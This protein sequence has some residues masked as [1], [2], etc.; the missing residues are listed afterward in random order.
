MGTSVN[1][2]SPRTLSWRAAQAGYRDPNVSLDRIAAEVWRAASNQPFGNLEQLLSQPII[3]RIG[4]LLGQSAS[5]LEL[6]RQS[7]LTVVQSKHSSLATEIARRACVQA[8]GTKD[9]QRDFT[10]KLI[11]EA[12]G[13]LVSRDLPGYVGLGRV[14]NIEETLS[15][16]SSLSRYASDVATRVARPRQLNERNWADHIKKIVAQLRSGQ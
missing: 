9:W 12:T 3:A 2:S 4:A 10:A 15:F 11:G 8:A 16:K 7:A 6:S 5:S 13:Y 1:Q 14:H